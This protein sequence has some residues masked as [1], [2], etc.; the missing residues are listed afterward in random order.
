[1]IEIKAQKRLLTVDGLDSH[2]VMQQVMKI[3]AANTAGIK[4]QFLTL[5]R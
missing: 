5:L 2:V 3:T 4:C 1:M